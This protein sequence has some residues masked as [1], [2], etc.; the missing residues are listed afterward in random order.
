MSVRMEQTSDKPNIISQGK[1]VISE[2]L[3]PEYQTYPPPHL[4]VETL[5]GFFPLKSIQSTNLFNIPLDTLSAL[6][7]Y[8]H[9]LQS[10]LK[11]GKNGAEE[12][13]LA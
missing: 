7:I 11:A 12:G 5:K 10:G 6:T 4:Y 3:L 1:F 8:C 13:I 2:Q 9:S